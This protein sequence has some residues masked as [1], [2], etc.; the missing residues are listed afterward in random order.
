[1]FKTYKTS[2]ASRFDE[3]TKVLLYSHHGFGKT[4]QC[5]HYA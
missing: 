1:M 2:T 5:R 4:Y 3:P